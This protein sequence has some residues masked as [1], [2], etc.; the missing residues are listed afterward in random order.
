MNRKMKIDLLNWLKQ[1]NV[2]IT[3]LNAHL[4]DVEVK[5]ALFTVAKQFPS[6]Y[7]G[8]YDEFVQNGKKETNEK[9]FRELTS[10][11]S[12]LQERNDE[13]TVENSDLQERNN[14][15]ANERYNNEQTIN[16]LNAQIEQLEKN[17]F[18]MKSGQLDEPMRTLTQTVADKD[19]KLL[20]GYNNDERNSLVANTEHNNIIPKFSYFMFWVILVLIVLVMVSVIISTMKYSKI[21]KHKDTFKLIKHSRYL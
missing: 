5:T 17:N 2:D 7:G 8:F 14:E 1:R 3:H 15:F 19:L 16:R 21:N 11:I 6:L 12:R 18:M 4:R 20:V 13:L 10:E 9:R